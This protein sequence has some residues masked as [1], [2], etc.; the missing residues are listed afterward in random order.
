MLGGLRGIL[1]STRGAPL[2]RFSPNALPAEDL[3]AIFVKRGPLVEKVLRSTFELVAGKGVHHHL[4]LGARGIGKTH[5]ISIIAHRL[6]AEESLSD[7]LAIAWLDE[8]PWRIR[9]YSSFLASI[10]GAITG[11]KYRA[12]S[13]DG[14]G[15]PKLLEQ[16]LLTLLGS[17]KLVLIVENLASIFTRIGQEGQHSLRALLENERRISVVA[18]STERFPGITD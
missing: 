8:D 2:L 16:A 7:S 13:A 11:Q 4:F 14:I 12:T 15:D 9:S 17:R 6:G 3:E 18:T 5:L 10:S 1:L